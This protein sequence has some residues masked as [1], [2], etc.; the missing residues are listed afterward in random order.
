MPKKVAPYRPVIDRPRRP[1]RQTKK[2]G[3]Q[4]QRQLARSPEPVLA[5]HMPDILKTGSCGP[6][7]DMEEEDEGVHIHTVSDGDD[8]ATESEEDEEDEDCEDKEVENE[9]VRKRKAFQVKLVNLARIA[10]YKRKRKLVSITGRSFK[11][12]LFFKRLASTYA[13]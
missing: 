13:H 2:R 7:S 4:Q 6:W 10:E 3:R 12:G 8:L 1:E 5:F 9:L 11:R